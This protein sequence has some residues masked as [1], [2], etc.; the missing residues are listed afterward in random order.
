MAASAN[1][2]KLIVVF[3]LGGVTFIPLVLL[4]LFFHAVIFLPRGTGHD[5]D[6]QQ[7]LADLLSDVGEDASIISKISH[8]STDA[9][10]A[11]GY[12]AVCREYVVW[13]SMATTYDKVTQLIRVSDTYPVASTGSR[14]SGRRRLGRPL[15]LNLQV[16]IKA[17]TE[18]CSIARR[19]QPA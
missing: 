9:D 8:G 16:Y 6:N 5:H 4:L 10:V 2:V 7:R 14:Q 19:N 11:A 15:P 3:L 1:T 13:H 17:S 18:A 12:Y